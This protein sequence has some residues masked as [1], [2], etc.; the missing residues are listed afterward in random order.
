MKK[1]LLFLM[2][3]LFMVAGAS[4]QEAA[5]T[6]AV[7]KYRT[8]KTA[9]ASAVMTKHTNAMKK[10]KSCTGSLYMKS[11][12]KVAIVCN[13]GKEQL[14]MNG[15]T[16]TMVM[17]GHKHVASAKTAAQFAAFKAVLL[18]V[19]DGG[20]TDISKVQG[21]KVA[22]NGG[23]VVVTMTPA[24]AKRMMFTS[25]V[26]TLNRKTGALET[27]RLNNKRGYTLYTFSDFKFGSAVND[28][29]F[30]P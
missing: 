24:Q 18:G 15:N 25:F 3:S 16:F 29:V 21:V 8:Q 19:L 22:T 6:Q 17:S 9:V 13:G 14:V 5:F 2:L 20:K 1:I 30:K 23:H 11:P 28:K 7:C 4:A 10:D 26:L 12:D 27:L